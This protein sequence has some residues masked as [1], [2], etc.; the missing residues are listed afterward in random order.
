MQN[1]YW[2]QY[3]WEDIDNP[4]EWVKVSAFVTVGDG[5]GFHD[6]EAWWLDE[7]EGHLPHEIFK[8]VKL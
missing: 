7:S 1:K 3:G 8:A 5:C 6:L 4:S 2:V